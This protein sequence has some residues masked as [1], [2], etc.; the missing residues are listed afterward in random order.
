MEARWYILRTYPRVEMHAVRELEQDGYETFLPLV[1]AHYPNKNQV[2]VP[3]F[4]GYLFVKWDS[5]TQEWP[6]F[7]SSNRIFGWIKFDNEIPSLPNETVLDLISHLD[8]LD[9]TGGR[10]HNFE[11]GERVEV[12][13]GTIIG[14]AEI[15]ESVKSPNSSVKVLLEFMGG[16]VRAEI[17]FKDLRPIECN[18]GIKE[19][20]PRRTR[21]R[22]RWVG[23]Y[24]SATNRLHET[25]LSS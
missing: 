10:W 2:Q 1:P 14:M 24:N 11:I 12:V 20:I 23:Q 6:K 5:N 22:G 15:T 18:P 13:S 16:L 4:P 9:R 7:R 3:L 19:K 21:G 17:P 25:A 8:S